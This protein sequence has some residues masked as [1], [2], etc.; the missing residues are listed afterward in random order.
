MI[1]HHI[2]TISQTFD[3]LLNEAAG[4]SKDI[5]KNFCALNSILT[6]VIEERLPTNLSVKSGIISGSEESTSMNSVLVYNSNAKSTW[7]TDSFIIIKPEEVQAIIGVIPEGVSDQ[8][9]YSIISSFYNQV[10]EV[11][12]FKRTDPF[13]NVNNFSSKSDFFSGLIC[14]DEKWDALSLTSRLFNDHKNVNGFP[15]LIS[16]GKQTVIQLTELTP[17][18]GHINAHIHEYNVS[19][20]IAQDA[21]PSLTFLLSRLFIQLNSDNGNPLLDNI[22]FSK[23]NQS[24]VHHRQ[25]W[26]KDQI[27]E[28]SDATEA[29]GFS[30][31]SPASDKSQANGNSLETDKMIGSIHMRQYFNNKNGSHHHNQI[32]KQDQEGN[33]PLHHAVIKGD[34]ELIS[35][36]VD[37]GAVINIK[38]RLGNTPL[39]MAIK[40]G[41]LSIAKY[42]IDLHADA[43]CINYHKETPLHFAARFNKDDLMVMLLNNGATLE[44]IDENGHSPL[45]ICALSGSDKAAR[46]L[47]DAGA[48]VNKASN[49]GVTPIH[50][51]AQKGFPELVNKLLEYHAAIDGQDDDGNTPLHLA[52][53]SGQVKIIKMLIS[54]QADENISN[55][56]GE[57]Y[58]QRLAYRM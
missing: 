16:K 57:T 6:Q 33:T 49:N 29:V 44:A 11:G 28:T 41:K 4:F 22:D 1:T 21:F 55:K 35:E 10:K 23:I 37:Q 51:A 48:E 8:Q 9:S 14:M 20:F 15:Q 12:L 53:A 36:L 56:S 24:V 43:D 54:F 47:M 34:K 32:N 39:H 26:Q 40:E 50:I 38:N 19:D 46:I 2:T 7:E 45:H 5:S 18:N 58:L 30:N 27:N 31:G 25:I 3:A 42:L 17:E 52:A 13:T